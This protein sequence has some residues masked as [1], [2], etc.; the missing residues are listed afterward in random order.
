MNMHSKNGNN[1][2][3]IYL[4][5]RSLRVGITMGLLARFREFVTLL[6]YLYFFSKKSYSQFSIRYVL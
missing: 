5:V 4:Y 1:Y 2:L 3:F 6:P